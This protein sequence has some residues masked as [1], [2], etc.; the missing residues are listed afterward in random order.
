MKK[1]N[2]ASL[3]IGQRARPVLWVFHGINLNPVIDVRPR[4][5]GGMFSDDSFNK[6]ALI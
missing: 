4:W 2:E 6:S 5:W 3:E 1:S